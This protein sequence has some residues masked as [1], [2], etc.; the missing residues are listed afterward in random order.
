M[1]FANPYMP[2]KS[3]WPQGT[4]PG[5]NLPP[6][7]M[8]ARGD[9]QPGAGITQP[10]A[11]TNPQLRQSIAFAPSPVLPTTLPSCGWR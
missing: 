7:S 11:P 9:G 2:L 1:G 4:S 10:T 6:A 8:S 5:T 3:C